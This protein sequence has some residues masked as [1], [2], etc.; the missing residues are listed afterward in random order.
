[1]GMITAASLGSAEFKADYGIKY[2]YLA[3]AMYKGI[4]S[5]ELVVALGKAGL[6]G[7][8]GT[9]GLDFDEIESSIRHI[10][11]ELADGQSYGMNLLSNMERP[12]LEARTVD[13]Y[14]RCGIRFV[15]AAAFTRI[16]PSLVR[17]RLKGL[18]RSARG[19]IETPHRI[20]AK[21]SRPEVAAVFMQPAPEIIV[22][23]LLASGQLAAME[24]DLGRLI[25]MA[26]DICVEADSG[27]HTDQGVASAL[28]PAM[29]AL[30]DEMMARY[31]YRK[32]IRVGAAGGIG[33][34]HAAAAAFIMGADFI[35]TGSINQ[36][37]REAGTSE[38][39]KSLLQY[40]NVQDT[41]YAPAG[42]LFELGAR[43]QVVRR[44]LFFAARANKLYE[45]YQRYNSLDEIDEKTR[46]TI[47]EK[48]F[49]RS[50]DE[51]WKE[52]KA[53]YLQVDPKKFEE[54]ERNPKRK[55]ALIFKWYFVH[56]TRLALEGAEDQKVD[57]QIHCG[58]ALGAFN[59]WIKGTEI[60]PW[61]N[62]YVADIAQRLMQ[63]TAELLN[64]RFNTMTIPN[65]AGSVPS[66]AA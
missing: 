8:L 64:E 54:I 14:F 36:C 19:T 35:L 62:R 2:A 56:T 4:A 29:I 55:M 23:D 31:G 28:V 32:R 15:E 48:Y 61:Q 11:A 49:R 6:L 47:Q 22:R 27:G 50:F 46:R 33:T 20:L 18:V 40:L 53:Y 44:G 59:Q 63:G 7:Y 30:R 60:E 16:T 51:V 1:M 41:A 37:T 9:G 26:D 12:E 43:V 25:P 10:Q 39:V 38:A 65:Q 58:P 21:V 42:D 57:Y 45:L 34:P 13:I 24:A 52:T 17:Y 66:R 3:G 5:K